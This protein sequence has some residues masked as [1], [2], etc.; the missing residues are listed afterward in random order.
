VAGLA[1][2]LYSLRSIA[3]G[4]AR[5]WQQRLARQAEVAGSAT[6]YAQVEQATEAEA[7]RPAP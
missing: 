6:D 1:Y 3:R 4:E 2:A 5:L 7:S